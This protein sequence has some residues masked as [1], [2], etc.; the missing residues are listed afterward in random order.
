[1][2]TYKRIN[3]KDREEISVYISRGET[4]EVVAQR[5]GVSQSAISRE[6]QKGAGRGSYNPFLANRHSCL[7]AQNR[8]PKLKINAPTWK[9]IEN[10]LAIHWS[11]FQ[12]A[13]FLQHCPKNVTV[14]SVSE[15]TIYNYLHFH[16]KG[17]LQRL[18][19]RELRQKGK[20]APQRAKRNAASF[21]I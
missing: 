12:I 4:Q 5:L 1:V 16:M 15:K 18:A 13:D 11:P 20:N 3:E 7:R 14:V 6:L 19:L 10:H 2:K 9:I 17:E 21:E 8:R